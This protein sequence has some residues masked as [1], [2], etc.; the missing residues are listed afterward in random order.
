MEIKSEKFPAVTLIREFGQTTGTLQELNWESGPWS[1]IELFYADTFR[2][3]LLRAVTVAGISY[4]CRRIVFNN[5]YKGVDQCGMVNKNWFENREMPTW[6]QLFT[7]VVAMDT[8]SIRYPDKYPYRLIV[9]Y[10][11]TQQQYLSDLKEYW[12]DLAPEY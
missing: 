3:D 1:Y 7:M 10:R 6:Q 2:R 8:G 4:P 5:I 11:Y 12:N 9:D